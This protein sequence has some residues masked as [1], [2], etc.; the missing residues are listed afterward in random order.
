MATLWSHEKYPQLQFLLATTL[1]FIPVVK[2]DVLKTFRSFTQAGP[3]DTKN[4]LVKGINPWIILKDTGQLYG[5]TPAPPTDRIYIH[6]GLFSDVESLLSGRSR[7]NVQENFFPRLSL[8][9]E[10]TVMHELVHFMRGIVY[11]Y[12]P[13]TSQEEAIADNFETAAYG[14]EHTV[15]SLGLLRILKEPT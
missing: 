4:M 15:T 8:L 10:V 14:K 1:P 7:P 11:G 13:H 6:K 12:N 2:P 9:F 3:K 5:L